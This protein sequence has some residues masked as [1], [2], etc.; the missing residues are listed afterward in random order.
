MSLNS[1]DKKFSTQICIIGS[2][3][4]GYTAYK[5]LKGKLN[6]ILV[7]GGDKKTPESVNEQINYKIKQNKHVAEFRSG[8]KSRNVENR[9]ETSYR[10]RKYTLGGSSQCWT[11]LIKPFEYSTFK[12]S[13]PEAPENDWGNLDLLSYEQ[14]ALEILEAPINNYDAKKFAKY[15]NLKLP[16]LPDN[17]YYSV[18]AWPDKVLRLK[19]YWLSRATNNLAD[20]ESAKKD[21]LYGYKL[22]D[23]Q[24]IK[25]EL[26]N[27]IF[28]NIAG[29]RLTINAKYFILA[30]GGIE[31]ARF[32]KKLNNKYINL[33]RKLDSKNFG[34]F[35]EHP[36]LNWIVGFKKGKNPISRFLYQQ[37][38]VKTNSIFYKNPGK[39]KFSTIAWDGFGSPK[40]SIEIV[41]LPSKGLN[42]S[43]RL[44][45][46]YRE[47]FNINPFSHEYVI[48]M[49]CEQ[50]KDYQSRINFE[51][52]ET[53]LNWR[54]PIDNLKFYSNYLKKFCSFLQANGYCDDLFLYDE[55]IANN[56]V[57]T[58]AVGGGH[59]MGTVPYLAD[60]QG[61]LIDS[62]FRYNDILNM[63]VIGTSSFPIVGWENPTHNAVCTS[64][65]AADHIKFLEKL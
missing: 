53:K 13:F 10:D 62:N 27:A 5:K 42:L 21:V 35:F 56:F 59:H 15:L 22:I 38:Q 1:L 46:K 18:L 29:Q 57:P 63:Y 48:F 6:L 3:P 34:H 55:S 36:H 25:G 61:S 26:K 8:G 50:S 52:T 65:V 45:R 20:I 58:R 44:K 14:E 41:K 54:L 2:G 28:E 49:R 40:A 51:E 12:N 16:D 43:R 47:I 33:S 11:G 17:F 24:L 30:M 39:I 9:L 19:K 32:I 60:N 7:E 64:L 4:C 31:N 23:G 37:N